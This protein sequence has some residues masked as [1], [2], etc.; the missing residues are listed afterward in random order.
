MPRKRC[1]VC[2]SKQWHKEP[3]SGLITCSEG[4]VLQNYRNENSEKDVFGPHMMQKRT[5]KS[6]RKKKEKQS[7]A[8]PKV[9]HGDRAKFH[10]FQC[11]Q[12]LLRKQI[13]PLTVLW[14]LPP[15]F[16]LVCRDLWALY[17]AV[18][19]SPPP[20]EPLL[21]A[22]DQDG[23]GQN[24][25]TKQP[26]D[27]KKHPITPKDTDERPD[28]GSNDDQA[29]DPS[30]SS[31][32]EEDDLLR[33]LSDVTTSEEEEDEQDGDAS[34]I[35]RNARGMHPSCL[36]DSP[37]LDRSIAEPAQ[38]EHDRSKRYDRPACT[39]AVLVVA[40]WTIRLPLTYMD[41][42]RLVEGYRVPF[43]DVVRLGHIPK[44]M[45]VHLSRYAVQALSPNHAPKPTHIHALASRFARLI[46]ARFGVHT[47]EINAA[48]LLWR[49]VRAL[50]G[51]PTLYAC[52]KRVA[53][54]LELPLTLHHSL[55][56]GLERT[57]KHDPGWHHSDN[58]P[59]EVTLI[60]VVIV[61][62]KMVYGLDG[63][64]RQPVDGEDAACALP[65]LAEYFEVLDGLEKSDERAYRDETFSAKTPMSVLDLSGEEVDRY[66]DFC[67]RTL[68]GPDD[69]SWK[70]GS[71]GGHARTPRPLS[72]TLPIEYDDELQTPGRVPLRPG[73]GYRIQKASDRLGTVPED[74]D[75]VLRRAGQWTG[76][77]G[78]SVGVV[79][80]RFE[81]RLVRWWEGRAR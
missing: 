7:A 24:D 1:P 5:L 61:V 4:H 71:A 26:K 17:V 31:S 34:S 49:A 63:R 62:L 72:A 78:D 73:Q 44:A 43:L 33:G 9:Y 30:S 80:E 81:R 58:A 75:R 29:G 51:S 66:L 60:A 42:L 46:Y 27:K 54:V 67:E 76:V 52:A 6:G 21:Y 45:A 2:Q 15:E 56:P 11:L 16:E 53:K 22:L 57:S 68:L 70:E 59:P 77:D 37:R 50:G 8:D 39:L 25:R 23:D 10:Y 64:R 3:A 36:F 14:G 41:I 35:K 47:P 74:Y 19:P 20:P 28:E 65:K 12:L 32:E 48:P 40:C 13:E 55:A 79:I 18:L 69:S 38:S